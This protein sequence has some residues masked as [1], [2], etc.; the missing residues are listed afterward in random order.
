M[1]KRYQIFVSSTHVGLRKERRQVIQT[2]MELNCIPAGV[3]FSPLQ[4]EE[5]WNFT[6]RIISDCDYYLLLIGGPPEAV[7]E[8]SVGCA[9]QEFDYAVASGLKVIAL[10]H[11][12]PDEALTEQP[13]IDPV[14]GE[15]LKAFRAKISNGRSVK[16]WKES[17]DLPGLIALRVLKTVKTYPAI[18]WT[19]S[20]RTSNED[21][22]NELIHLRKQ[23]DAYQAE[24]THLKSEL[25][26]S[27][28]DLADFDD[29]FTIHGTTRVRV[30]SDK[31]PY[32]RAWGM[33]VSWARIFALI[34][35]YLEERP[36][37]SKVKQWLADELADS[38]D[39]GGHARAINDQEFKTIAIQLQAYGLIEITPLDTAGGGTELVWS[40]TPKGRKTMF[41]LR[42]VKKIHV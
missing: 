17:D 39:A 33:I 32:D 30:G 12:N 21:I 5:Q 6:K 10:A 40:L 16:F 28:I 41:E 35:P 22:L 29:T 34:A 26:F 3:E 13:A 11:E 37:N 18:G 25:Q 23:N 8:E 19:R 14:L 38:L 7:S 9:E 36:Q 15:K 27:T 24:L 4:D 1:D 31:T 42:T 2:L 20:N